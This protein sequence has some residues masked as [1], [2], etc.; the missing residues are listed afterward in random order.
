MAAD[1]NCT[2]LDLIQKES[3][4]SKIDLKRYITDTTGLPTLTDIL[5][6]LAKPGRDPRKKFSSFEFASGIDTIEDLRPGMR[7]EIKEQQIR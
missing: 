6:E 4:R 2:V 3:L 5:E 1:L 7:S